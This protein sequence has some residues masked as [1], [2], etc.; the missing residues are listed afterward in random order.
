MNYITELIEEDLKYICSVI[1]YKETTEYFKR[2]PKEFA[3]LKPGFRPKSLNEKE[4]TRILFDFRNRD[5]VSSF[6]VKNIDRWLQEIQD[7]LG[8]IK[9]TGL[10]PEEIYINVL[11]RSV[12]SYNILMV[13]V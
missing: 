7:A 10:T 11:S 1:P 2:Y 8:E 12:F 6:I 3:R 5:F 9:K 13:S 4:A